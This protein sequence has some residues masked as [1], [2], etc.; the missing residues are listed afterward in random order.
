MHQPHHPRLPLGTAACVA[1]G[2]ALGS[3]ARWVMGEVLGSTPGLITVNVLG[4]I[5]IGL[6]YGSLEVR[7]GSSTWI[8]PLLGTGFLGGFTT[9]SSAILLTTSLGQSAQWLASVGVLVGLPLAC[10]LGVW[11]G[12]QMAQIWAASGETTSRGVNP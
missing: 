12:H 6:L 7:P 5:L 9:F 4:C 11:L 1:L 3:M 2:G 8:K 10:V